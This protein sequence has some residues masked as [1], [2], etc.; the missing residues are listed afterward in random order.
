M[1]TQVIIKYCSSWGYGSKFYLVK[2][3][4]EARYKD[5][6][7]IG[8]KILG[9]TGSFEVIIMKNGNERVVHSKLKG[10][11]IVNQQNLQNFLDKFGVIYSEMD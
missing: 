10:E 6:Q 7:V 4:L 9:N 3:A 1:T 2:E 5:I 8:Q 11:G